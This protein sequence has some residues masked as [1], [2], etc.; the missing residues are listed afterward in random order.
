MPADVKRMIGE[1][2]MEMVRRRGLDKVTVKDLVAECGVS[3]QTFYYHFQDLMEVVEWAVQ[4]RMDEALARSLEMDS[5]REVMKF[6]LTDAAENSQM[7]SRMLNSQRREQME[8]ILVDGVKGY[9]KALFRAR[10]GGLALSQEDQEVALDF[11]ACGLA[12]L[13]FRHCVNRSLDVDALAE[14]MCRLLSGEM[15]RR[16]EG[17]DKKPEV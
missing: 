1:T 13:I 2:F 5:E 14:R 16:A 3:R 11:C 15:F 6:F 7:I 12:G 17:A 10:H 8:R 9:L 4:R